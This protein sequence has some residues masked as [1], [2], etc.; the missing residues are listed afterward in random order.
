MGGS[1]KPGKPFYLGGYK[2]LDG[3][4]NPEGSLIHGDPLIFG[5]ALNLGGIKN[6]R[7]INCIACIK[8]WM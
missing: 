4:K 8:T 3:I 6:L 1:L 5:R 7:N 2:N